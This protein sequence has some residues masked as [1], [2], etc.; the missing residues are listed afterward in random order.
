MP[1]KPPRPCPG[2]GPRRG[3]CPNLIK[4]NA[5]CCPECMPY[6]KAATRRYDKKRDQTP[7]RKWLHSTRWRRASDLH[8]SKHPLCAECERHG[9][10]TPVYVTDHIIA[11]NGNYDLFWDQSNWQSLC[12]SCHELKHRPERFGRNKNA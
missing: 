5:R 9:R 11:H 8:K 10:I 3:A 12:N 7:E 4:G 1:N 6:E 2:Y